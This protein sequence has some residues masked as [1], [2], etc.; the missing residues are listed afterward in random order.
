M[1]IESS[2]CLNFIAEGIFR[3]RREVTPV[4]PQRT[5]FRKDEERMVFG[6]GSR[7]LLRGSG[8]LV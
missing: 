2:G 3:K 5:V 8:W 6:M 1:E 7:G 4:L